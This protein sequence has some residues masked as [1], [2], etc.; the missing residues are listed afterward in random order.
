MT[1]RVLAFAGLSVLVGWLGT[2]AADPAPPAKGADPLWEKAVAMAGRMESLKVTPGRMDCRMVMKKKDGSVTD[3][4]EASYKILS[5]GDDTRTEIIQ[6]T[7]NG[8]DVTHKAREEERKQAETAKKSKK[9]GE[10]SFSLEPTYHPFS[11]KSQSKVTLQRVGESRVGPL[12]AVLYSF[13]DGGAGEK[14]AMEGKAWLDPVTGV[15]LQ[16]EAKPVKLPKHADTMS[17]KVLFTLSPEGL[18]YADRSEVNG[19]GGFL[20]IQRSVESRFTF[21]EYRKGAGGA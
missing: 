7:E 19:S 1:W 9:D 15:P 21:S 10:V 14:G 20:W 6:V 13:R 2:L 4:A 11:P 16:V 3:T 8:K 5:E 12:S 18:W 17:L